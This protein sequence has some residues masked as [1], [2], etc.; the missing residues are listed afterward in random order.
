MF[1]LF[2]FFEVFSFV[3]KIS[4]TFTFL[5]IELILNTL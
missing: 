5:N 2:F 3:Q 1:F 4:M